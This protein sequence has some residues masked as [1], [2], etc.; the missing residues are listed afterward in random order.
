MKLF[1]SIE[2]EEITIGQPAVD[3]QMVLET[4]KEFEYFYMIK[5][6]SI[7]TFNKSFQYLR[8]FERGSFFGDYNIIFGLYSDSYY[9]AAQNDSVLTICHFFKVPKQRLIDLICSDI[10]SFKHFHNICLQKFRFNRRLQQQIE[11]INV[12][13]KRL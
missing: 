10:E 6:G 11:T 7:M 1:S 5:K 4:G 13:N 12:R 8:T 2:N 9:R 3:S